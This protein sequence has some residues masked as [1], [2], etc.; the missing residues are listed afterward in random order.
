MGVNSTEVAYGFGQ[1]GSAY[2]DVAKTIIPPVN[3]VICAITFLADNTPTVLTSE[4][5]GER[6]HGPSYINI[7]ATNGDIQVAGNDVNFNGVV[8]KDIGD[9]AIAAGADVT[10]TSLSDKIK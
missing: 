4:K 10:L 7:Q 1:L 6:S 5:L 8:A 3:H 2:S 9:G